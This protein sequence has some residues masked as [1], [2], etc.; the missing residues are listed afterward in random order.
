LRSFRRSPVSILSVIVLI[1]L[2]TPVVAQPV[3]RQ[4]EGP[5]ADAALSAG[6]LRITQVA[7]GLSSP[8]G[9]ANAGD[10][11]DRL[12]IVEQ[13]GT[14]RVFDNGRLED[15]VFLD[16]R[17]VA[18]GFTSGGE[19]GLL[20]IAFHPDFAT[21]HKLF[22][23]Y[24]DG[25]G[26]LI[27]AELTA[28]T[29]NT[30]VSASTADTVVEVEHSARTNHNGGQ[31]LF[32]P[33][34]YLYI[35]TGDGGGSGDPDENGQDLN[36][37]L[38]K[39]LRIEP[40]LAGGFTSPSD[41]PFDGA[42]PGND[43][44]WDYGLRNPWRASFDR[45]NG[46]L[47]IADVGQGT[48]EEINR[49]AG[50]SPGGL[51]YGWDC[52]EGNAN[53]E[54]TGC[55]GSGYTAPVAVY[56]HGSGNCSVTGGYVYRGGVFDDLAGEYV[57]GDYCSGRIWTLQAG[58]GSPTLQFH[59]DTS[60]NITSFGETEKG[61]LY[62][63]GHGGELYRVVAPPYSD[64]T[65]HSLID[66]IMWIT[67]EGISSGCGG[68]RY[69]PDDNVTRA[70][71]AAF[72]SRALGLPA[73]DEDFFTDDDGHPLEVSINRVAEA[74]ITLGCAENRY[75]PERSVTRGEMA[76]FLVR[77]FDLPPTANDY[78]SDDET[79]THENNINALRRAGVTGGCTATRFCPT[80]P[81]TRAEMAAFLHRAMGD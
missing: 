27:I 69:C 81:T 66:H 45:A 36:E 62:M 77:A 5:R 73:T 20:S 52:R 6:Q 29:A 59:R 72:L 68:G 7:S 61:E 31:L 78:F 21:N 53:F 43:A 60:A 35:F 41:N 12:F 8:V 24:T 74:G 57:L 44:I 38:G 1:G 14:V 49:E 58:V 54:T 34:D 67:Y 16:I 22:A 30:A 26:D 48:W 25:G 76:S 15:G 23:Y 50:S 55:S 10:G 39:V 13:G 80:S 56:G 4:P 32:G 63:T 46:T 47:W 65:S 42:T 51:N 40:N 70:E 28:N 18:G 17:G 2:T 79:S 37:T 33:D 19:R 75:C 9:L 64:V 11:S 71:M 3:P